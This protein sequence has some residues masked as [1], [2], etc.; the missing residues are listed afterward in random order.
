[1]RM[2]AKREHRVPLCGR[3]LEIV[4]AARG[5]GNGSAGFVFPMRSGR[6]T[7]PS[8]LPKMLQYQEIPAVAHDFRSSFRD[9]AAKRTDYPREVIEAA[10]AHVV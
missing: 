5:L 8:T 7:S 2:K 10:L 3:A 1:M 9:W 4:D 6:P